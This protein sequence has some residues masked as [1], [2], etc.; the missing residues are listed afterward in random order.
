M[1][2]LAIAGYVSAIVTIA[3]VGLK[4]IQII[5]KVS[6]QIEDMHKQIEENTMYIMKLALFSDT[7]PLT[8]RLHAGEEYIKRGGNGYGKKKYEELLKRA[9]V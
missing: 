1:D 7:L 4:S 5:M 8:D 2:I 3:S 6:H 9:E